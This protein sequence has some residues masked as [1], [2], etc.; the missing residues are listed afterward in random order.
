MTV[1]TWTFR[2]L[3][4]S[5][6]E[7]WTQE[8]LGQ[9]PGKELAELCCLAGVSYSGTK[10]EKVERLITQTQVQRCLRGY[11]L[12]LGKQPTTEQIQALANAHK[13]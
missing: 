6:T 5:P 4:R 10:K 2:E 8:R 13:G 1:P 3:L 9:L 11:G 7:E 12:K